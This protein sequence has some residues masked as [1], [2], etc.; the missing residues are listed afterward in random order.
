MK[1]THFVASVLVLLVGLGLALPLLWTPVGDSDPAG[2]HGD[3]NGHDEHAEEESSKGPHGGRL[4]RQESF[5]LEIAIFERGVPPEFRVYPFEQERPVPPAE[6]DLSIDLRRLGGQVDAFQ[7]APA[8]DY[9][10]GDREVTEPYSFD[11]SVTARY[12][13][14][15]YRW[16]YPS[17]E[18]RVELGPEAVRAAKIEVET[19]GPA[20][21][22][23]TLDLTGQIVVNEDRIAHMIPRF[24]GVAKDVRKRLG[25]SVEKGELLAIVQSNES[26][27]SYEVR[28]QISGT[29]IKKHATPGE[30]VGQGEDVYVVADLSSVWVDLNV[31]RQDFERLMIGQRIILD[32]GEGI[33]KA[34][35]TISYISPF[36]APNTQTMLARTEL[37]NPTG[38]WRPGLFVH[39]KVIVEEAAVPVAVKTSALQT[40]RDWKVV[41]VQE[42]NLFEVRP[43][44]LG[45]QDGEWVEVLSG[46]SSGQRYA[47]VNS[48]VLKAE[49]GKAGATHDH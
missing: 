34:E 37:P 45:R 41:F 6:V 9:L 38:A 46:L 35:S 49:L 43:L 33:P 5:G 7:F 44:E 31:Y 10:R 13:G 18:G 29:V 1:R 30:F 22:R 42:G 47:A 3:E 21:V 32:A 48:F 12:E 27:Q 40:F 24:P 17:Y 23:T 26:L 19:A 8:D 14:K 2:E 39:G 25:D 36:G 11:V 4:L 16:E 28:S 15:T 20:T